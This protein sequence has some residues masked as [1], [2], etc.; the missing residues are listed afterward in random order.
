MFGLSASQWKEFVARCE[1]EKATC[2]TCRLVLAAEILAGCHA[3]DF[4]KPLALGYGT[5]AA[6]DLV[7]VRVLPLDRDGPLRRTCMPCT[8]YCTRVRSA[9]I[10]GNA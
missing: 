7:R 4:R 5:T 6:Y 10:A 9:G 2:F 3:V 8:S 1:S